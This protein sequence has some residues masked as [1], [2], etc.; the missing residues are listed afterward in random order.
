[1]STGR[2]ANPVR[3]CQ[4]NYLTAYILSSMIQELLVT[5]LP[6]RAIVYLCCYGNPR[7]FIYVAVM[8]H[9][10]L[11]TLP[12]STWFCLRSHWGPSTWNLN[13][14]LRIHCDDSGKKKVDKNLPAHVVQWLLLFTVPLQFTSF[15]LPYWSGRCYSDTRVLLWLPTVHVCCWLTC[16]Y[17]AL[18]HHN[19]RLTG[20]T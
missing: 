8:V 6:C 2:D 5:T 10:S 17:T 7:V 14:P 1:M 12:W 20:L 15:I 18:L 3:K 11:F 16:L 9:V 13:A 19:L 4:N